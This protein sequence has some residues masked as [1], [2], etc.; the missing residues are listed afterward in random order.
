MLVKFSSTPNFNVTT[1]KAHLV[2]SGSPTFSQI[3]IQVKCLSHPTLGQKQ[4]RANENIVKLS[5]GTV[6]GD[7]LG[8]ERNWQHLPNL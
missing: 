4:I 8:T 6:E 3:M 1:K 7:H 2:G 5:W